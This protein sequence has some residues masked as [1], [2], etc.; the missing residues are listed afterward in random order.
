MNPAAPVPEPM[1]DKAPCHRQ[2]R[3]YPR[4]PPLQPSCREDQADQ[5]GAGYEQPAR[6]FRGEPHRHP[7]PLARTAA[8]YIARPEPE[9][10]RGL[11][12]GE[13]PATLTR[14]SLPLIA[15]RRGEAG[16]RRCRVQLAERERHEKYEAVEALIRRRHVDTAFAGAPL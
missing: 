5:N 16:E 11:T 2:Q 6:V 7:Q 3:Q 13:R 14:G 9:V 4:G 1:E 10:K 12:N 15:S 8:E